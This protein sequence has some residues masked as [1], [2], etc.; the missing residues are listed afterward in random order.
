MA[1]WQRHARW[2]LA[3]VAISVIAA[4]AY[5]M[6]P[7]EIAAPVEKTASLPPGVSA[8][9]IGGDFIRFKG[10]DRDIGVQFQSQTTRQDGETKLQGVT[11]TVDNREGRSFVVTGK[12]ASL[13]KDNSSFDVHGDVK[14]QTNDGLTATGQQATY[15]EAEKIVKVPGDVKFSRG[16]MTGSGVGFTYDEQRDTMWILDRADIKFAADKTAGPMAFKPGH[17]SAAT[18]GCMSV[19]TSLFA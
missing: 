11:I 6:R 17:G 16:R 14:L 1:R 10:G 19:R 8:T 12:E 2:V 3:L 18:M 5:T 7:R 4:V 15:T 9:T 13:G